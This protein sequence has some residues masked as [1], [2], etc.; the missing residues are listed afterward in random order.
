MFLEGDGGRS[1]NNRDGVFVYWLPK[2]R[3]KE[4]NSVNPLCSV[5]QPTPVLSH[6]FLPCGSKQIPKTYSSQS[7]KK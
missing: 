4:G 5:L 1:V 6:T 2:S 7:L 3:H